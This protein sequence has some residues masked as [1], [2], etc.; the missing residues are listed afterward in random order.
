MSKM[1]WPEN[2]APILS[3]IFGGIPVRHP[4]SFTSKGKPAYFALALGHENKVALIKEQLQDLG[5]PRHLTFSAFADAPLESNRGF[6]KL[7]I[8]QLLVEKILLTLSSA[9]DVLINTLKAPIEVTPSRPID[10]AGL[11]KE[12][13]GSEALRS[14]DIAPELMARAWFVINSNPLALTA[15]EGRWLLPVQGPT[16]PFLD[17]N[18]EGQICFATPEQS[19]DFRRIYY[20]QVEHRKK[21]LVMP[22][23]DRMFD[24]KT[25]MVVELPAGTIWK[26]LK[27]QE[28]EGLGN[29]T[30]WNP[31]KNAYYVIYDTEI[32]KYRVNFPRVGYKPSPL[33]GISL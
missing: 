7:H 17:I 15:E 26:R 11:S 25:G 27:E 29:A 4:L 10:K 5:I 18:S 21:L 33:G 12:L 9:K 31:E 1:L 22:P 14:P 19:K 16:G 3:E 28:L 32:V 30:F 6:L 20:E 8:P 2:I 13:T 24:E 23:V